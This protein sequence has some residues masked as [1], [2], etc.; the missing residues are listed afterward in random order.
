MGAMNHTVQ[1]YQPRSEARCPAVAVA[2]G[3]AVAIAVVAIGAV[4]AHAADNCAEAVH[5]VG[6]L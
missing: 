2:V 6:D 5:R 4:V 3:I 1:R